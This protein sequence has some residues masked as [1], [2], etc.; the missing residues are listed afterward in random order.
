MNIQASL[1]ILPNSFDNREKNYKLVDK[2]LLIIINSGLKYKI[3]YSETTVE[4]NSVDVMNLIDSIQKYYFESK[5]DF[6]FFINIEYNNDS[7][8]IDEKEKSIKNIEES[9]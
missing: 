7:T 3:G 9:K 8:Y 1:K 5:I 6:S 2:T 4:G